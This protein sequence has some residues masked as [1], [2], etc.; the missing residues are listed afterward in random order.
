VTKLVQFYQQVSIYFLVPFD[1]QR[2][3]SAS[4][5]VITHVGEGG[6]CSSDLYPSQGRGPAHPN[7]L[8]PTYAMPFDL[9]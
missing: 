6:I 7:F 8:H 9:E 3:N 4:H 2:S 1:Y 5:G